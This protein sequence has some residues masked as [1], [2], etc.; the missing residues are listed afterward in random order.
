MICGFCRKKLMAK[1]LL[2]DIRDTVLHPCSVTFALSERHR[3]SVSARATVMRILRGDSCPKIPATVKRNIGSI[4]QLEQEFLRQ[5]SAVSC[6]SD[7]ITNLIASPLFLTA[8]MLWFVAWI[9]V[10]TLGAFVIVP[11][12]PYPFCLLALCVASETILLT[13]FVLR[14]QQRQTR[15]ADQWAHVGLQVGL[16]AEQ[17]TTKMLQLL[18]SMCN[19]LGLK[20]L[21]RDKELKEMIQTTPIVAIVQELEKA[22]EGNEV[23]DPET[24][25]SQREHLRAA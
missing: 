23:T 6:V 5:R 4:A 7:R 24:K 17:E 22:R 11:F 14:S 18:Q 1:N 16:L 13:T 25:S 2:A 12:D 19:Q 3:K 9:L 21:A 10:N 20:S 15:S 8:H